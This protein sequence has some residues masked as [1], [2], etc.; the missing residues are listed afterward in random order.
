MYAVETKT[1]V[2]PARVAAANAALSICSVA[3][4]EFVGRRCFVRWDCYRSGPQRY[5][6]VTHRGG[7]FYPTWHRTRGPWGGTVSTAMS[8]LIRWCQG[9]PVL[10]LSS[11]AYWCG[12]NIRLGGDRGDE[13][14]AL[15]RSAGYPETVSCVC[16]GLP[17][18]GMDWWCHDGKSGPCCGRGPVCVHR[19]DEAQR[20][21]AANAEGR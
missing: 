19:P 13:L 18:I 11:F 7:D 21:R 14:V 2:D 20:L 3:R 1:G 10:P 5:Q 17:P 12:P 8:Q 9:K 6:W 4:L 16:C 15:L